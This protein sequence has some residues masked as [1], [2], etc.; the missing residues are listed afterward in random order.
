[1]ALS[2]KE[3]LAL[4]QAGGDV[5]LTT[6]PS[7]EE[8]T[9]APVRFGANKKDSTNEPNSAAEAGPDSSQSQPAAGGVQGEAG[10]GGSGTQAV[11]RP[12]SRF[13]GSFKYD[14]SRSGEPEPTAPVRRFGQPKTEAAAETILPSTEEPVRQQ[15]AAPKEAGPL[16]TVIQAFNAVSTKG[17]VASNG[18]TEGE[19]LS[20]KEAPEAVKQIQ[21]KIHELESL[22][23]TDLRY[24]MVALQA[25]LVANPSACLYL[26]DEDTGLAVRA[27]R[28]MTNNRVA[29]DMAAARPTKATKA[30]A[31]KPLTQAELDSAWDD[32]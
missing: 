8:P 20:G 3:R 2:F 1:M 4:R 7:I 10:S 30:A 18:Q 6:T 21:Q 16:P 22:D 12:P 25:M 13:G 27:L 26:L 15:E 32:L 23:D 24:E 28:R 9:K 31:S 11:S 5:P 29:I 19:L 17:Q 14:P